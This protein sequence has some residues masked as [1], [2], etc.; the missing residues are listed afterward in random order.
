MKSFILHRI[1]VV[2]PNGSRHEEEKGGFLVILQRD[3][4]EPANESVEVKRELEPYREIAAMGTRLSKGEFYEKL[5]KITELAKKNEHIVTH[6]HAKLPE[7]A[8]NIISEAWR[9]SE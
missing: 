8:L 2:L 1:Y 6:S 5:N 9:M 7:P 3:W 4:S